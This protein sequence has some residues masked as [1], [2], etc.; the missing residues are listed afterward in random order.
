MN[1][2]R[3]LLRLWIVCSVAWIVAIGY[4]TYTL[5]LPPL[6]PG[7]KYGAAPYPPVELLGKFFERDVIESH[8]KWAFGPPIGLLIG[9]AALWWAVAGF[10]E[11]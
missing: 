11:E 5:S 10:R 9:G 6:P 7:F 3:G 2:R 4:D 8:V 1:L